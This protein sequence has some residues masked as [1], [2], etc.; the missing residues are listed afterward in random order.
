MQT[1]ECLSLMGWA[2]VV[3]RVYRDT[4]SRCSVSYHRMPVPI[5]RLSLFLM[6]ICLVSIPIHRELPHHDDARTFVVYNL[7][8]R[9]VEQQI[10][11]SKTGYRR[12]EVKPGKS[13]TAGIIKCGQAYRQVVQPCA[14]RQGWTD[15]R[16]VQSGI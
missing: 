9:T 10:S 13:R 5:C 14:M 4:Y 16:L 8:F 1:R 2:L 15:K 3:C 12:L 7:W 11:L 6:D